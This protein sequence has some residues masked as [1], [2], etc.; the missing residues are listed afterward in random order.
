LASIGS[1]VAGFTAFPQPMQNSAPSGSSAAGRT[2]VGGAGL[3]FCAA[4]RTES[5]ALRQLV[6]AVGTKHIRITPYFE[7]LRRGGFPRRWFLLFPAS[8][9]AY[10]KQQQK[11][12][13]DGGENE[14]NNSTSPISLNSHSM[15]G[16]LT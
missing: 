6:S 2:H 8:G 10:D 14:V 1:G 11:Q 16:L 12:T 5:R 7:Y 4:A 15:A 13:T 3:C 9:C